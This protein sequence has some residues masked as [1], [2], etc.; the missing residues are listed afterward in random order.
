[1]HSDTCINRSCSKAETLFTRTETFNLVCFLYASLSHLSKEETVKRTLFQTNN[2]FSVLEIKKQ[3]ALPGHN[4]N[5]RNSEK[6]R[7][8][9]DIFVNFLTK[10]H[11]YTSKQQ[12]FFLIHFKVLKE[13]DTF[14]SNSVSFFTGC[15]LQLTN[16]C[17]T[18]LK[19]IRTRTFKPYST[20]L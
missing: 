2:F 15:P 7:I 11:F 10:K 3:P 18:S 20:T 8:K 13:S 19:V 5:F 12:W 9:F 17:F 16:N 14:E 6:Q 4:E 1:M